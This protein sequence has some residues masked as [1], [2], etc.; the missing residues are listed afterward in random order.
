M[1]Y[2]FN[3]RCCF[4]PKTFIILLGFVGHLN[5][6]TSSVLESSNPKFKH[7]QPSSNMSSSNEAYNTPENL[8]GSLAEPHVSGIQTANAPDTIHGYTPT[9]GNRIFG[10][11]SGPA[12]RY[13]PVYTP[14]FDTASKTKTPPSTIVFKQL[15]ESGPPF[16]TSPLDPKFLKEASFYLRNN[17]LSLP[18]DTARF[19][20]W[21]TGKPGTNMIVPPGSWVLFPIIGAKS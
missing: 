21:F 14:D 16:E 11:P 13:Y 10:P 8:A 2:T 5:P 19:G 1:L 20:L 3:T 15:P 4:G 7:S 12:P 9:E 18:D 6:C 17:G